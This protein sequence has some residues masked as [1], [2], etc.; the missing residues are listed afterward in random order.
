[1]PSF[2]FKSDSFT[3]ATTGTQV[4]GS[5]FLVALTG[6]FSATIKFKWVDG[7]GVTHTVQENGAD[8]SFTTANER[9]LDF[10]V[11]VTLYAECTTYGS[12]TAVVAIQGS[13]LAYP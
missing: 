3:S 4:K 11:P 10:G 7:G 2:T 1:M 8:L 12:G 6:T 9:V 13:I 5:R